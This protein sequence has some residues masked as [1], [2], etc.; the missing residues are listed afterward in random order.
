M[1]KPPI[2]ECGCPRTV[3]CDCYEEKTAAGVVDCVDHLKK[4][5]GKLRSV[6]DD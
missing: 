5:R 4:K 6:E 3:H 2:K 1:P